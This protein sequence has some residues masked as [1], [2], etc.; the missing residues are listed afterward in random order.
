MWTFLRSIKELLYSINDAGVN[1]SA[2]TEE[3]RS[4]DIAPLI[5]NLNTSGYGWLFSGFGRLT[6][7]K[8]TGSIEYEVGCVFPPL[9]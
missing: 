9:V 6:L 7:G 4:G 2:Y 8:T 3:W 5:I 1:L